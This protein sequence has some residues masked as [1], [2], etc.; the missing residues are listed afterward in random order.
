MSAFDKKKQQTTI[1]TTAIVNDDMEVKRISHEMKQNKKKTK[2]TQKKEKRICL[3]EIM[4]D[5]IWLNI[6]FLLS[7]RIF[8]LYFLWT[9]IFSIWSIFISQ[10]NVTSNFYTRFSLSLNLSICYFI[11]TDILLPI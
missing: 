4:Q 5:N 7:Q 3:F 11:H 10:F 8:C 2:Q 1:K 9:A 6:F